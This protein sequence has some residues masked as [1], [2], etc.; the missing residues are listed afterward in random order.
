[1]RNVAVL[2]LSLILSSGFAEAKRHKNS[3]PYFA[4]LPPSRYSLLLQNRMVDQMGLER[5]E[6][7]KK[8][9][10]RIEDETLVA[11]PISDAVKIAPSLP[12]NR[13][14]VLPLTRQ[15]ILALASDYY[16]EFHQPL[17]VDSA[18]RPATVQKKLHRHNGCAAPANGPTASSHETGA[19]VDFSR[20]MSKAQTQWLEQRLL[21]YSYLG[22]VIVEEERHCFHV[23]VLLNSALME[24]TKCM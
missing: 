1:M 2:L 12:S 22:Y 16:A 4:A 15:F 18:V 17:M 19:T 13:R 20:R 7:E 23:M 14:Y 11:L 21:L 8:L 10:R 5:I 3:K 24:K 9:S 6:D